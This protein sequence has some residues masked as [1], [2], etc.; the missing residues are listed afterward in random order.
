[1]ANELTVSG[2]KGSNALVGQ[3]KD[4]VDLFMAHRGELVEFASSVLGNHA[5]GE[6]VVQEAWL[7]FD[8]VIKHRFLD[9][10]LGYLFRIVRNIALDHRRQRVREGRYI[11]APVNDAAETA[12]ADRPSPEAEILHREQL[13]IVEAALAELPERTRLAIEMHRL[14]GRKLR[15]IADRLGI[16]I[17]LAHGL[18][19][20]GLEHCRRRLRREL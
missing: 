10:P 14:E 1:V 9:E 12:P 15:E 19:A 20:E 17:T 13:S 3:D 5:R 11:I 18:I 6:D 7:R 8:G 4:S 2:Q 16:S